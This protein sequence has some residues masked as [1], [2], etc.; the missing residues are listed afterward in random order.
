ML[1]NDQLLL[2]RED[3]ANKVD[4]NVLAIKY[5][6]PIAEIFKIIQ[7]LEKKNAVVGTNKRTNDE[8]DN[9]KRKKPKINNI[10][11][12]NTTLSN[13]KLSQKD[14]GRIN[15]FASNNIFTNNRIV[16]NNVADNIFANNRISNNNVFSN[17]VSN[18]NVPNN[19]VVGNNVFSNNVVGNNVFSNNV[20]GNN[21]FSNNV[22]GNNVFSNNVVGNNVFS[23]NVP[24]INVV[25][26]KVFS[27]N[28]VS[29]NVSN[30][31]V[32]GN[33]VVG[34]NVVGNNVV[35]NNINNTMCNI[36]NYDSIKRF[37]E[38]RIRFTK[39]ESSLLI[40][41]FIDD[42]L[43]ANQISD[44]LKVDI[45]TIKKKLYNFKYYNL[46]KCSSLNLN[47]IVWQIKKG[48]TDLEIADFNGVDLKIIQCELTYIRKILLWNFDSNY[49]IIKNYDID[50]TSQEDSVLGLLKLANGNSRQNNDLQND[51]QLEELTNAISTLKKTA[52]SDNE[53]S[54]LKFIELSQ[55]RFEYLRNKQ[56]NVNLNNNKSSEN[57]ELPK[58]NLLNLLNRNNCVLIGYNY[59]N[60]D[61]NNNNI[62]DFIN[63]DV[64]DNDTINK[65]NVDNDTINKDNVDNDN[66]EDDT[67]NKDNVETDGNTNKNVEKDINGDK[68]LNNTNI[69]GFKSNINTNIINKSL[70]NNNSIYQ[71]FNMQNNYVVNNAMEYNTN[72]QLQMNSQYNHNSYSQYYQTSNNLKRYGDYNYDMLNTIK[73]LVC[74]VSKMSDN[75]I[76][77]ENEVMNLNAKVI[78]LS[79]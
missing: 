57:D 53:I 76:N 43:T 4:L 52:V 46:R 28:V 60:E 79:K 51:P 7:D 15:H 49:S 9:I 10:N 66:I 78:E 18:N 34:N 37:N 62:T 16:G 30:N 29:N 50:K 17:N 41:Y 65:D 55:K 1:S 70:N 23:N 61:N 42:N 69:N 68:N 14:V 24:N 67:I 6:K 64:I 12:A 75:I 32:V 63:N 77:L 13:F 54:N 72:Y 36:D 45:E 8:N 59:L 56:N 73:R 20:V 35:S 74:Q 26:G 47:E 44:K 22:V 25:S 71:N 19:N 3:I 33:N 31:N 5:N 2:F 11:I 27:N 48:N 40:K 39:L 38:K 21:V 58:H